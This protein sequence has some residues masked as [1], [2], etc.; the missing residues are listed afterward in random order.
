[1]NPCRPPHPGGSGSTCSLANAASRARPHATKRQ[2]HALGLTPND[3][4]V[5]GFSGGQDSTCLLHALHA[6]RKRPNVVAAHVDHALRADSAD[7]AARV[8]ELARSIG[9]ETRSVRVDVA[10]YKQQRASWSIQH[11]A[12]AAR[13]Q[14]LAAV[15]AEQQR[16]RPADGAHRRRPGRDAAAESAARNR[17]GGSGRHAPGRAARAGSTRSAPGASS[18]G[19]SAPAAG[20]TLAQRGSVDHARVLRRA[21]TSRSSKMLRTSRA[22]TREIASDSTCCL[23]SSASTRP[24]ARFLRVP[25]TWPRRTSMR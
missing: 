11:A 1:M 2:S 3:T 24:S 4:V 10:S 23:R 5:V 7:D 21:R 18:R 16:R 22:R 15:V 19:A 25:P 17:P 13:Y 6:L 8:E 20:P 9:V 14:A 12:R